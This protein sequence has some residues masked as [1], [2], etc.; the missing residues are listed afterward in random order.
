MLSNTSKYAIRAVIYL[1][2]HATEDKRIGIKKI[3]EALEIPS[4]FLGKILQV[5]VR[6]KLLSSTK[7]PHGGFGVGKDPKEIN[8]YD[9]IIEMDGDDLFNSCLLG[10]GSCGELDHEGYC[11]IHKDFEKV[12][13]NM[14]ELYKGKTIGVLAAKAERDVKNIVL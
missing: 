4:P 10:A 11:A 1:A 7:G 12:R 3:A 6:R 9:I 8:L 14:V 13:K 5:L 2:V